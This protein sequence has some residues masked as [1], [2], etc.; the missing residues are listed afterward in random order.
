MRGR[1]LE[2]P[3]ARRADGDDAARRLARRP[4]RLRHAVALAV[5]AVVERVVLGDRLERVEAD[6]ELD[7]VRSPR[8]RRAMPSSRPGVRCS[9]AVG[10][11]AEPGSVGVD[12]LVAVGAVE[13][14]S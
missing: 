1:A 8:R 7:G 13:A 14:A 5:H 9:P 12:R 2:G 4:R 10:A 11:A 6:D 3:H